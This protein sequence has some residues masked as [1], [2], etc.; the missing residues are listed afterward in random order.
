MSGF[1]FPIPYIQPPATIVNQAIDM[2]GEPSKIIARN[3]LG[4]FSQ[5]PLVTLSVTPCC[6]TPEIVGGPELS[7]T[8]AAGSTGPSGPVVAWF[9]PPAFDAVTITSIVLPTSV[10]CSV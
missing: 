5:D 7:A 3:W 9:P 8:G 6:A 4:P 10:D 2:M 1:A